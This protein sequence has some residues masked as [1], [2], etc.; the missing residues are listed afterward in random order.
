MV[1]GWNL[2]S[3]AASF[4]MVLRYSSAV[5]INVGV[6]GQSEFGEDDGMV[7]GQRDARR[8]QLVRRTK[9]SKQ[10]KSALT[11]CGTNQ[12]KPSSKGRFDHLASVNTP[13]RF[14]QVE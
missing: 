9:F 4:P 12:M 2:L 5:E 3:R 14:A 10:K 11:C 1:T 13:F 8:K 6:A 7:V